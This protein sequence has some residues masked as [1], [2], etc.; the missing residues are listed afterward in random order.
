MLKHLRIATLLVLVLAG[1]AFAQNFQ[2]WM[3]HEDELVASG[4]LAEADRGAQAALKAHPNSARVHYIY[5]NILSREGDRSAAISQLKQAGDLSPGLTFVAPDALTKLQQQLGIVTAAPPKK[6]HTAFWVI[7]VL[8]GAG[9]M[10]V[11]IV[12]YVNDSNRRWR[13]TYKPGGVDPQPTRDPWAGRPSARTQSP[14]GWYATPYPYSSY[15]RSDAPYLDRGTQPSDRSGPT[16]INNNDSGSG[17]NGMLT[18][19]MLGEMMSNNRRDSA[20]EVNQTVVVEGDRDRQEDRQENRREEREEA[21]RE[22]APER[23]PEPAPELAP[24]IAPADTDNGY[25]NDSP[26]NTDSFGVDDS[27][28]GGGSD[29]SSSGGSGSGGGW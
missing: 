7:L 3:H 20:P 1:N 25:G 4:Q 10:V 22:A 15:P 24:E 17:G 8:L 9:V 28:G 23:D 18:G 26:S 16:I 19:M 11:M 13:S 5:A 27:S 6:S 29:D 12:F 2:Q 21:P 14:A